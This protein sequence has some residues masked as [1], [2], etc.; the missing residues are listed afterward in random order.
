MQQDHD[1]VDRWIPAWDGNPV[2]WR[3][4]RDEVRLWVMGTRL[5]V[6]YV[7]AARL[8]QRLSGAARRVGLAMTRE[9]LLPQAA[10]PPRLDADGA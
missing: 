4:Y 6:N 8:I 2:T 5:D 7:V 1:H 10:A 3:T 9:E